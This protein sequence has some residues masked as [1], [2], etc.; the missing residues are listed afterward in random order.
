[1]K[2]K[3]IL[4]I[5]AISLLL[6]SANLVF[7]Q[8]F[9][10]NFPQN[11]QGYSSPYSSQ[12]GQDYYG[13]INTN[14][15]GYAS[16]NRLQDPN[17]F[18]Q[19]QQRQ[20]I[21]NYGT[22]SR[23]RGVQLFDPRNQQ[24]YNSGINTYNQLGQQSYYPSNGAYGASGL[25]GYGQQGNSL[26]FNQQSCQQ[27]QNTF[28]IIAP[29][30][31]SPA[32]VRSDLLEEQNVPVFC[33]LSSLQTNPLLSGTKIRGVRISGQ[34]PEGIQGVSYFPGR[35]AINQQSIFNRGI[36]G[37]GFGGRSN[38]GG[39]FGGG[40]YPNGNNQNSYYN[41]N[42]QN[43][44]YNNYGTN[45][46]GS[47]QG[48]SFGSG[49]FFNQ[50][51]YYQN[52][53]Q[54]SP[55]T[56]DMGYIVVV[57]K[58]AI[59]ESSLPD[60]VE[61]NITATI[62]Y[63]SS[64]L[65]GTGRT[66]FYLDQMDEGQWQRNYQE[67]S[68]WNGQAYIRA[69]AVDDQTA[70]ISIYRDQNTIE[71]TINLREGETSQ[72]V[73]LGGNF[74]SSGMTIR[75]DQLTPPVDSALVQV[76]GEQIWVAKGDRII[77]NRC[78]VQNILP[79]GGGGSISIRCPGSIVDLSLNGGRG[80]FKFSNGVNP[81]IKDLT[82]NQIAIE[83]QRLAYFGKDPTG[84]D[85]AVFVRDSN[86]NNDAAF[87]S[88]RLFSEIE[89][90]DKTNEG[91]TQAIIEKYNREINGIKISNNDIEIIRG[92]EETIS[93]I[94]IISLL[95]IQ[96][97]Q[98]F[99]A[100]RDAQVYYDRAMSY[101]R[102]LHDLYPNE[103]AAEGQP[104]YA[105]Q[106][107]LEG[108]QLSKT[109]QMNEQAKEFA[110]KI[111]N[112]Y[113]GTPSATQALGQSNYLFQ[114]DRTNAKKIAQVDN[115]QYSIDLLEFKSP[116]RLDASAVLLI[117]G[118]EIILG[119]NEFFNTQDTKLQLLNL[120]QDRITIGYEFIVD[121]RRQT[122]TQNLIFGQASSISINDATIRLTN[123]NLKKQAKVTILP[124]LYGS[125]SQNQVN[126]PVRIGIEKRAIQLSPEK[127]KDIIKNLQDAIEEWNDINKKLGTVIKT[128]KAACF[129]T[130]AI[131]TVKNLFES[132][133]GEAVARS[134][135]MKASGGWNEK[136]EELVN[137]GEYV[138]VQAC[139][140]DKNDEIENDIKI[141][142]GQIQSTNGQLKE[143]QEQ[144]GIDHDNPFDFQGQ[145]DSKKVE[146]LYQQKFDGFCNDN[147]GSVQLPG[148]GAKA[149]KYS[150]ICDWKGMTH[151]QRREILTLS[152]VKEQGG[153]QVLQDYTNR[154]LG[155]ITLDAQ[156][157]HISREATLAATKNAKKFNLGKETRPS[158]D[159]TSYGN[160]R[161]KTDSDR[162][163]AAYN[164]FKTGESTIWIQMP[165]S[166]PGVDS[167][168]KAN[169][170]VAG[171]S[172]VI[173]M[174]PIDGDPSTF[175]PDGRIYTGEGFEITDTATKESV[176]EYL[177]I[178]NLNRVRQSNNNAIQNQM[179][180]TQSLRVKF[181]DRA[182]FKGLP[183]IVPFDIK[184][185]WY[186]KTS[187]TLSGF[188]VPYD[189]SGSAANYYICNVGP[190]GLIEFKKS[191]D[192]ICRYYNGFNK[193]LSFPG[194]G[195]AESGSLVQRARAA[196]QD[197]SR[198]FG[199]DNINI[200]GQTF[201]SGVSFDETD[202]QCTDFMSAQDCNI[203]FN[204][205]DPVIC[206]PSR[207]DLGGDYRVDNVIQT[208][209]IGS[210]ALC[211]PNAQEGIA[212][213]ICLTGVHAG[214]DGYISILNSTVSC[215]N[216]SLATGQNI[217]ICDEIKSVY[218]CV[219]F[220]R[221]AAPFTEILL[222]KT[223]SIAAGEGARGGGEYLTVQNAW[224]N[225]QNAV[226]FFT[227]QY[228]GNS[229]QAFQNRNIGQTQPIGSFGSGAY[230]GV[231]YQNGQAGYNNPY[232][233][234]FGT[235]GY[236]GQNF[237]GQG[238]GNFGGGI[239]AGGNSGGSSS[240]GFGGY[241]GNVGGDIC[242]SFISGGV[243]GSGAASSIF[244]SL[245]EP[246]SPEQYTAWFSEFPQSTI[247][248]PPTSHY[249]VYYHIFAGKDIGAS[250]QVY[251]KG[252]PQTPGIFSN[253]FQVVDQ[254]YIARGS[255]VD[256]AKD[257]TATSGFQQLCI[258]INGR[259]ECGFG[260]VSTSFLL[261][262]LSDGYAAE[263]AG[264]T[265]IVSESTC[266]AGSPSLYSLA[267]PNLQAGVEQAINPQL[268][269]K[270]IVR[271]CATENP[272][273]QVLP[274]GEFDTTN[275]V[276][277]QWKDVGYCD[278]TTIRCWLDTRSVKDIIK[279]SRTKGQ[280]LGDVNL[281]HLGGGNFQVP[282][283]G[284]ATL[285]EANQIIDQI[286]SK[287][288]SQDSQQSIDSRIADIVNRLETL[289]AVGPNNWF[290]A[291]ALFSLGRM[292]K[293]I[294]D[295]IF[296]PS[297]V[298]T[299]AQTNSDTSNPTGGT[300]EQITDPADPIQ[301]DPNAPIANPNIDISSISNDQLRRNVQ[302][303]FDNTPTPPGKVLRFF[304]AEDGIWRSGDTNIELFSLQNL[305]YKKSVGS[306][307]IQ[308][309]N[310]RTTIVSVDG[311]QTQ[312][313][314]DGI[315]YEL[316]INKQV[317]NIPQQN[318]NQQNTNPQSPNNNI[319]TNNPLFGPR[320]YLQ[321]A[322]NIKIMLYDV[323]DSTTFYEYKNNEWYWG[324]D[325]NSINQRTVRTTES[326][327]IPRN[328]KHENLLRALEEKSYLNGFLHLIDFA[329]INGDNEGI[330]SEINVF[331]N[332]K[333]IV[334]YDTY[335]ISEN[336]YIKIFEE[337]GIKIISI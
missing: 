104:T 14:Q 239:G 261:N 44:G 318:T 215:L 248:V 9:Q 92:K 224:Q 284:E 131:L 28:I 221:Q 119:L 177:G 262:S 140:L 148:A 7:T 281:Q 279:N 197:A 46:F 106:G 159:R 114:Y 149:V 39:G 107:L 151:E 207:C 332:N 308:L 329:R 163:H 128:M 90:S 6:I 57:L 152:N 266:I 289:S 323:L 174:K 23:G 157:T 144:V 260:Q 291:R 196:I 200:N 295:I 201:E 335:L 313:T 129:A 285:D 300:P 280:V 139:L 290:R 190:N 245:I 3:I 168:F 302:I 222:Q 314:I 63:E 268:Y 263:Q 82:L 237:G 236:Q 71:Q 143:I 172:I 282:E 316:L 198:Q 87:G 1:M 273:K 244:E 303:S 50:N 304:Y 74:C 156:N 185:G 210:L 272:G 296:I 230:G 102:E 79:S 33:R 89:K 126:F 242:K 138:S 86:A 330:N 103:K 21:N 265:D 60:F 186:V 202:G 180:D 293:R 147:S 10:G 141:F 150:D 130:S 173:G 38:I 83:N 61:G 123:V 187:Y 336:F 55:I 31:C 68:F 233:S 252:A 12:Y 193:D 229:I 326:R 13:N 214:L 298:S 297:K 234:Q 66:T 231:G 81:I 286:A 146:E 264:A 321:G 219:F 182:P 37:G 16:T 34:L 305:D 56:D 54:N 19:I 251:L 267:Q 312:P 158:G 301:I 137:N 132:A 331:K 51:P 29:G 88:L 192:D 225:T 77:N 2:N 337:L 277:D 278:D 184:E 175:A 195:P 164:N 135:L 69:N 116:S 294:A 100:N 166:V 240:G 310:P 22:S 209:I 250:Y 183:S 204:V 8:G 95:T 65:L 142:S 5:F 25:F 170:N 324:Y 249:K 216:E 153:S 247:T 317:Q 112:T 118:Q 84:I 121:G 213:P 133:T 212:V 333:E 120:N 154:E 191:S 315:I 176:Q 299:G 24:Q 270:G 99:N 4:S 328:Q 227:G 94:S 206:P 238:I 80:T 105:E 307:A 327:I 256:R 73:G 70:Q 241:A 20:Q 319:P 309:I 167:T 98:D 93:R 203:L 258:N 62:D 283:Q 113:P 96:D 27:G 15:P 125:G 259:E 42:Q 32:V 58:R 17:Y 45:N 253:Q 97:Q 189:E 36:L 115:V 275:S 220:W 311:I 76:N 254:G 110:D 91:I 171:K 218:L 162:D 211:L 47:N 271:I 235:Q 287:I 18:G 226:D 101:Y 205:C 11:N 246:D 30:G 228:A 306:L 78:T 108:I 41:Y 181:F 48:G 194:L 179:V 232:Q 169:E 145:T 67:N 109:Y 217:G 155:R 334:D 325:L 276:Y 208:G 111:V 134:R 199:Q 161:T 322:Q 43:T 288:S 85:L 188:G 320:S 122:G 255:E 269:N 127:T 274:S 53:N 59:N 75:L 124:N 64:G 257:F 72:I 243:S 35:A 223:F 26:G 160:I 49:S 40:S 292:H 136:C 178:A 165:A 117:N 52:Q